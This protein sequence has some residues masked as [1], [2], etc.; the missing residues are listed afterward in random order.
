MMYKFRK[1]RSVPPHWLSVPE[2]YML[3]IQG[4]DK[5]RQYKEIPMTVEEAYKQQVEMYKKFHSTPPTFEKFK[6]YYPTLLEDL[7]GYG[8]R[9]FYMKKIHGGTDKTF[10]IIEFHKN[11]AVCG[12]RNEDRATVGMTFTCP[13]VKKNGHYG[14]IYKD[15]FYPYDTNGGWVI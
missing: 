1:N 4:K 3:N 12:W 8:T 2:K 15:K 14:I 11:Y 6:E 7:K 10:M 5:P 13:I 9:D